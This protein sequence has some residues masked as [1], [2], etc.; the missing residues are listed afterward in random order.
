MPWYHHG[1]CSEAGRPV[2][3]LLHELS[4]EMV[5]LSPLALRLRQSLLPID[6]LSVVW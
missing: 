1:M 6:L 2:L 4:L 5:L 3:V